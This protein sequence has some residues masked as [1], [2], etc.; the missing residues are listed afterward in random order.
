MTAV[1][2]VRG[3]FGSG[4]LRTDYLAG[5]AAAYSDLVAALARLGRMNE[6]FAVSDAARATASRAARC[7]FVALGMTTT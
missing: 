5:R 4:L 6:A 3:N 1:E 2:R 7:F